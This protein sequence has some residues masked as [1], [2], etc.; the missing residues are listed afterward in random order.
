MSH[1]YYHHFDCS[2]EELVKKLDIDKFKYSLAE[3][4]HHIYISDI[5]LNNDI[6]LVHIMLQVAKTMGIYK[7]DELKKHIYNIIYNT[8]KDDIRKMQQQEEDKIINE[9][10]PRLNDVYLRRHYIKQL[11]NDNSF[12]NHYNEMF[13]WLWECKYS[14]EENGKKRAIK[15]II[16]SHRPYWNKLY[17]SNISLVVFTIT[18]FLLQHLI[19]EETMDEL[20]SFLNVSIIRVSAIALLISCI[21]SCNLKSKFEHWGKYGYVLYIPF[22]AMCL[23]ALGWGFLNFM[24][25][26]MLI[27]PFQISTI[28][29]VYENEISTFLIWYAILPFNIQRFEDCYKNSKLI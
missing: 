6:L 4:Q 1:S 2:I 29:A 8:R 21:L 19:K 15:N 26:F 13:D 18:F 22:I 12:H 3:Y 9:L 23:V 14:H 27:E 28:N 5:F 20:S 11:N 7:K 17:N 24:S 10:R 25:Q 16:Y